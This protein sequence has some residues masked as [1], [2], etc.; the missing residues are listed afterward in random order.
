MCHSGKDSV[1]SVFSSGFP[2][3]WVN[4]TNN[5]M[6]IGHCT[7]SLDNGLLALL[8]YP[9]EKL[10]ISSQKNKRDNLFWSWVWAIMAPDFPKYHVLM[11]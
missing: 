10:Q 6:L 3:E 9:D 2:T 7:H 5:V 11:R 1:F 4:Y 8:T